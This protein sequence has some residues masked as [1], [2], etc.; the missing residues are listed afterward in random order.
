MKD[1][2]TMNEINVTKKELQTSL[3][4]LTETEITFAVLEYWDKS[5]FKANPEQDFNKLKHALTKLTGYPL[6]D[7]IVQFAIKYN[8]DIRFILFGG[9][10]RKR[11]LN[12]QSLPKVLASLVKTN[13]GQSAIIAFEKWLKKYHA[14]NMGQLRLC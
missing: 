14:Y 2:E 6:I 10:R 4:N 3:D 9:D 8:L 7:H 5:M 12:I 11:K 1:G 13:C